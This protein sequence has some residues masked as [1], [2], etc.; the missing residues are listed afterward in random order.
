MVLQQQLRG[1]QKRVSF[2][3]TVKRALEQLLVQTAWSISSVCSEALVRSLKQAGRLADTRFISILPSTTA[4]PRFLSRGP[5][6]FLGW[7]AGHFAS[8][9]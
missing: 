5:A 2:R 8:L 4:G 9:D 6:A 3:R 7:V 1:P